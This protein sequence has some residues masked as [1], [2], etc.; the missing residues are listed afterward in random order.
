MHGSDVRNWQA[1]LR[2]QFGR[3]GWDPT[4]IALDG[5]YGPAT[6]SFTAKALYG[7]GIPKDLMLHGV[8][9][10]LRVKVRN[11]RTSAWEKARAAKRRAWVRANQSKRVASPLRLIVADSWGWHPG[12]HD[13]L[14]L[15]CA[16]DSTL[17]AMAKSKVIRVSSGGWWGKAPSGDVRLG[18][19]IVM[20][21]VAETVGPFR[22]GMVLGYG[23]AEHAKVKVGDFVRPG[24]PIA[25]AGLAVVPHVH[26]MVASSVAAVGKTGAG[27]P[28]GIGTMDPEP[29]YRYARKHG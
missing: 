23:H 22:K 20:L 24:Q 15:I 10:E 5:V 28:K 19:G 11:R 6:R 3:W 17:F 29:L 26:L 14:D 7:L 16:R 25:K 13:G 1:D 2:T 8:T 21:E 27:L 9:P 18:D 12:V 4:V